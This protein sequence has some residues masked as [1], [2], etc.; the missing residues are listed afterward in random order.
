MVYSLEVIIMG[1]KSPEQECFGLPR[2]GAIFGLFIGIIIIIVGLQQFFGW[3]IDVGP[4]A[5]IIIGV[6]FIAGA[7]YG[8]M[9]RS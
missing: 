6:L 3:D 9:R 7:L 4:L 5:I 8:L 2:G 1:Q